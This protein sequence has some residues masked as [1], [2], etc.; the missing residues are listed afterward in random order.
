MHSFSTAG[1][2][3]FSVQTPMRIMKS[4][5]NAIIVPAVD[6]ADAVVGNAVG[7]LAITDLILEP[8]E[9]Q[10]PQPRANQGLIDKIIASFQANGARRAPGDLQ[11]ALRYAPSRPDRPE[12]QAQA[13][14]ERCK[15]AQ[16]EH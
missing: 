6:L 13:S 2:E 1:S 11:S 4:I 15:R 8:F 16:L 3:R 5:V 9:V 12:I 14:P 10:H 7:Q